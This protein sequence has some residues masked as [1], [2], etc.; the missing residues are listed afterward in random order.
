MKLQSAPSKKA[1]T[2]PQRVRSRLLGPSEFITLAA[3]ES[4]LQKGLPACVHSASASNGGDGWAPFRCSSTDSR[5][6]KTAGKLAT[7]QSYR[8]LIVK[9]EAREKWS[10]FRG[11]INEGWRE[12]IRDGWKGLAYRFYIEPFVLLA[13]FAK[14]AVIALTSR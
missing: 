13:Q 3:C 7:G 10:A 9:Q 1:H 11:G 2:E 14:R 12:E 8:R 6:L 4:Q 5:C